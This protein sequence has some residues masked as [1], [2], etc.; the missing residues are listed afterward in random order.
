MLPS[1]VKMP[2][3]RS[4]FYNVFEGW[5][6]IPEVSIVGE[7]YKVEFYRYSER[8]IDEMCDALNGWFNVWTKVRCE[9]SDDKGKL[10]ITVRKPEEADK[11]FNLLINIQPLEFEHE[12]TTPAVD[13]ARGKMQTLIDLIIEQKR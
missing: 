10:S 13:V 4:Y 8:T 6:K 11:L 12:E 9:Y 3:Y 1:E 2:S 7:G 5:K